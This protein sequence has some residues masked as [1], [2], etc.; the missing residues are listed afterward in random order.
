MLHVEEFLKSKKHC[1]YKRKYIVNDHPVVS[2]LRGSLEPLWT[3][4]KSAS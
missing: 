1:I 4:A 3:P 2:A